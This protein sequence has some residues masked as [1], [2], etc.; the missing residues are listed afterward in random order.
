[1]REASPLFPI[2]L[3]AL[4]NVTSTI[5]GQAHSLYLL[6]ASR[7]AS[8]LSSSSST[9]SSTS[10]GLT[11]PQH[12]FSA[13]TNPDAYNALPNHY[14]N[15]DHLS[16]PEPP[17][18]FGSSS[19]SAQYSA[20]TSMSAMMHTTISAISHN[21]WAALNAS[22]AGRLHADGTPYAKACFDSYQYEG[23]AITGGQDPEACAAVQA[24]YLHEKY[25]LG[26]F[27]S[28]TSVGFSFI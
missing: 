1:M 3:S 17:S 6:A 2:F 25:R 4:F 5:S 9:S 18:P 10:S 12:V 28:S 27:G 26:Y 14:D 21:Q 11:S 22:V 16:D 19:Y 23:Q 24:G 7:A 20:S 13:Q 15:D 8:S